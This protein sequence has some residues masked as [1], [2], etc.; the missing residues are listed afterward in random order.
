M[1]EIVTVF[2]IIFAATFIAACYVSVRFFAHMF[3]LESYLKPQFFKWI[4]Q[5]FI[6]QI[7]GK[8]VFTVISA[9]ILAFSADPPQ[10]AVCS[11]LNV[12]T[13]VMFRPKKAKKP[14]VFTARVKRL[15]LSYALISAFLSAAALYFKLWFALP[16]ILLLS[17]I[18]LLASAYI[19]TPV[20]KAVRNKYINEAKKII[21]ARKHN[22]TVI[23]IT[24][25]YGKTSTKFYLE[26]I[27]S[28]KYNVLMTPASY[29]TTMGVVKVVREM[30]KPS[31]EI[32]ICEMG[33]RNVGEIK[34]ICDIVLPDIGIIT[35]IGP[36]HLE[37]F[38]SIENVIKTK[39]E[40]ADA[41]PENGFV[42]LN[43]D[44][45]YINDGCKGVTANA[46][47]YGTTD[48][49][50]EFFADEIRCSSSGTAFKLHY[51]SGTAELSTRLL[52]RH[53]V[54][55]ILAACAA[56]IKLGVDILDIKTAVKMLESVPHRLQIID[57]G[58]AVI[59]DDAFN[60]NPSGAK[61]AL[62]VLKSFDGLK[63][64]VTPGMVELGE[65]QYEL[66]KKFGSQAAEVCDYIYIVGK[67][68]F[69]SISD[70]ALANGF[71][72]KKIISVSFP[73]EAV[74]AARRIS[75]QKLKYVLLENDLPD[76]FK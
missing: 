24:G 56:G 18:S 15:I 25:S 65:K 38:G 39:F 8:S 74:N 45:G 43:S 37:T 42:I 51:P 13:A 7:L 31:H 2:E 34:E 73:E 55:N 46:V 41:L 62:D 71:D 1:K 19:N 57:G 54:Q 64:L 3:Q 11:V 35:S 20:E 10:L 30:L 67:V 69:D 68:N 32:F 40:L 4:K 53:N 70:G 36:Q 21:S 50:A 9:V 47:F 66:N 44:C 72:A 26:K 75:S 61:A 23:G 76:N 5:N 28:K 49:K 33:A 16:L 59:I 58:D 52:G 63:I 29:N 12:L 48:E 17:P 27:L 60:S 22:L 6:S 14:L